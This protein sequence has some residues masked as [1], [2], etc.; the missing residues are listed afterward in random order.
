MKVLLLT[1][2]W[3][4]TGPAGPMLELAVGL[5]ERGCDVSLACPEPPEAG[6]RGVAGEARARGFEPALV[7]SRGRGVRPLGDR[8]DA[9][10][11]RALV[12]RAGTEVLHAWHTRDHALALRAAGLRPGRRRAA[13]VRSWRKAEPIPATPWDRWLFGPGC[14]GLL[15]VSPGV[16]ER[17]R[18]VRGRRPVRGAFGAVDLD[19]FAPRNPD[20]ALRGAL[21]L[22]PG[23]LVVGIVARVQAH[24]RFDLLLE[25]FA[26]LARAEPRA[27]FLVVGRG[28]RRAELAEAPARR[29]GLGERVLFAGYRSDDYADVL[30]CIDVFT[31]LVPGSDGTCRALLEAQACGIP[32]VTTRRGSL[33]EIV[34]HGETGLVVSEDPNALA[35]AWGRLLGEPDERRAFGAAARKRAEA[36]FQPAR[37]AAEVEALYAEAVAASGASPRPWS[38]TSSR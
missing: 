1:G 25:A 26:R 38:E 5:R 8:D 7:L 22:A 16:A 21:G 18:P 36:L 4:W 33:A 3:K 14:D 23:D 27:H 19:R 13:V 37:L 35:A 30:G 11:L 9:R 34:A 17:C 31:F 32:A 29:L 10:R 12:E 20:A 28:T 6:A 15:C 2:D 24:R